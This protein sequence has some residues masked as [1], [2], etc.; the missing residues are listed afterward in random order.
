[1]T[2]LQW[3]LIGGAIGALMLGI[4]VASWMSR[5]REIAHL[6]EWRSTVVQA[7]T[8]ATVEPDSKGKRKLLG[9]SAVPAAIAALK[10][11][12]DSASFTLNGIDAK[13]KGE[14]AL[15]KKLDS[16]LSAILAEQDRRAA[17]VAAAISDLQDRKPT[18][19]VSKDC[20]VMES[21]SNMAW[22]GW[23]K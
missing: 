7:A 5:G 23:R 8:L 13:A 20:A 2:M 19:D 14:A 11:S 22:D 15:S 17:G 4:L 6:Q 18:G 9:P 21:D 3:K 16:N 1:M 10:A 12:F